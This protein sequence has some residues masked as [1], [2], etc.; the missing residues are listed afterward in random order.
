VTRQ[1]TQKQIAEA[2]K[3]VGIVLQEYA[4]IADPQRRGAAAD[5]DARRADQ[6]F[7][8][9]SQLPEKLRGAH[10]L[11]YIGKARAGSRVAW[12]FCALLAAAAIVDKRV[13]DD[14]LASFAF[15]VLTGRCKE[16]KQ[17]R[18]SKHAAEQSLIAG[19]VSIAASRGLSPLRSDAKSGALVSACDVVSQEL[20]KVKTAN[21]KTAAM[22]Y[23]K[24][25]QIWN[26]SP[27]RELHKQVH[28]KT[29]AD[30]VTNNGSYPP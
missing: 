10:A 24:I 30:R 23:W 15:D 2:R 18:K 3:Y 7:S 6:L 16:P 13:L 17:S 26:S 4:T 11:I 1:P 20:Q 5:H 14:A 12:L 22:S 29:K 21:G 9:H 28:A 8:R 19:A 25:K 27:L